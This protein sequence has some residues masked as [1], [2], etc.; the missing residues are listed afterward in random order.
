MS[1]KTLSRAALAAL[2]ALAMG[3]PVAVAQPADGVKAAPAAK[4]DLRSPDARD[5]ARPAPKQDMRSPDARDA[6]RP[7]PPAALP[8][9]PTWP[10]NPRPITSAPVPSGGGG[11]V[12]L[13]PVIAIAGFCLVLAMAGAA[14]VRM[15]KPGATVS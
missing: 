8:G 5:A 13:P 9:P 12:S 4:Q 2:A 15:R 7:R 6:A 11:G 1:S 10:A 3:A 14:V